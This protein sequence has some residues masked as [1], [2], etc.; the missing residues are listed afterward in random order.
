MR[1][2]LALAAASFLALPGCSYGLTSLMWNAQRSHPLG[3]TDAVLTSDGV[4]LADLDTT[5][6]PLRVVKVADFG[7]DMM[8]VV[9][10]EGRL[11]GGREITLRQGPLES[12]DPESFAAGM[13]LWLGPD[14]Q[15]D[16]Q[17]VLAVRT[18]AR[19]RA[20]SIWYRRPIDFGRWQAWGAGLATPVTVL[21]DLV[22][23]APSELIYSMITMGAQGPL[24]SFD[25][26]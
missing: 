11:P 6:G 25:Q 18:D 10:A 12:T 4:V 22:I 19:F 23:I 8:Q 7:T 13:W 20:N 16:G 14:G 17:L 26:P 5:V 15:R 21:V 2:W 1:R 24:W 9:D 3:I